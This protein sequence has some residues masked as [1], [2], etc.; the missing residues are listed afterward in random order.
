MRL[1]PLIA[2][3]LACATPFA[4]SARAEI[5]AELTEIFNGKATARPAKW[6]ARLDWKWIP[7]EGGASVVQA[8]VTI[9]P[10]PSLRIARIRTHRA[11]WLGKGQKSPAPTAQLQLATTGDVISVTTDDGES[12]TLRLE[13]AGADGAVIMQGCEPFGYDLVRAEAAAPPPQKLFYLGL[14]CEPTSQ[15]AHVTITAPKDVSWGSTS[16]FEIGGKGEQ[17]RQYALTPSSTGDRGTI[18]R[19]TFTSG[20]APVQ[21]LLVDKRAS[22]LAD[23]S[24]PSDEDRLV[25]FRVGGGLGRLAV[26]TVRLTDSLWHA[27][28]SL[29]GETRRFWGY[30]KAQASI[31]LAL[32]LQTGSLGGDFFDLQ[33]SLKPE[34]RVKS[35]SI[36]P[37]IYFISLRLRHA[38]LRVQS[39]GP[40]ARAPVAQAAR[41]QRHAQ[42]LHE[43][44][45]ALLVQHLPG[46]G[47]GFPLP[48]RHARAL[49]RGSTV[50]PGRPGR[51]LGQRYGH[52]ERDAAQLGMGDLEDRGMG[53]LRIDDQFAGR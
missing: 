29:D 14:S 46:P 25:R 5:H 47:R 28:I 16:I 15:G 49:R 12:R 8:L 44:A 7:A 43:R 45:C 35:F 3:C 17:W 40:G 21:I 36:A 18:G 48:A 9:T 51:A 24:E 19:F 38:V 23:V 13:L 39:A 34:F 52:D 50:P 41:K 2:A 33:A 32:P 6:T 10:P 42:R 1:S 37:G 30:L 27:G 4:S 31:D 53:D 20:G 26:S 11:R 22:G